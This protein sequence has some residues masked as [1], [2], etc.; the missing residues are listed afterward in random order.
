MEVTIRPHSCFLNSWTVFVLPEFSFVGSAGLDVRTDMSDGM[1]YGL[2]LRSFCASHV[3][4]DLASDASGWWTVMSAVVQTFLAKVV[5]WNSK[6][7]IGRFTGT[8]CQSLT[9]SQYVAA[10]HLAMQPD[11][12][13]TLT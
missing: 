10:N 2:L 9:A 1:L 5:P 12:G 6:K 8:G 3:L 7:P 4:P 11:R 13:W